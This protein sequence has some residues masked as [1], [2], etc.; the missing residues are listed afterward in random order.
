MGITSFA[1][2][3][4]FAVILVLYYV[5][6]KKWQWGF[7][8]LCS[9]GYYLLSGNPLLIFYPIASVI[10]CYVGARAIGATEKV[11]Y[12]RLALILVLA[13]N[14]GILIVLKYLNFGV[15]TVNG[16]AGL[17][18]QASVWNSIS[19]IISMGG[20][21]YTLT[22]V[23]YVIDIY[24]G[25]SVPEKNF[26]KIALYGL[27]FPTMISGPILRYRSCEQ[28]FFTPH[29]FSYTQVT[30]GLQRMVWGFLK[31]LVIAERL[32]TIVDTVYGNYTAYPGCFIWL[33]AVCFVF[34]LYT[35]FSGCMDIVLGISECFGIT[36]PE[37]FRTPFFSKT[38]TE[39]WRRWHMT[40]G[41]WLKD[42]LFYPLLRTRLFT[43]LNRSM[44]KKLGKKRG[45]QIATFAAMFVLWFMVGI[46]HGGAWHFVIGAGLLHWF[47]IVM[48][49]LLA[50]PFARLCKKISVN[51]SGR[52]VNV[53]RIIRTF[54][55][56]CISDVFFR[57]SS[58]REAFRIFRAGFSSFQAAAFVNGSLLTLGLE[59]KDYAVL[60]V[61]LALL[62]VVSLLQR[63]GSVRDRIAKF[64]LPVRWVIWYALLFYVILLGCYGPGYAA[65]E[66]IYQGF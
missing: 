60:I 62:F 39:Y 36:L 58:L 23:G 64:K 19:F 14:L 66:F 35:D 26:G 52:P 20:S 16:I 43:N 18:G 50:P 2:L 15:Y 13:V 41:A 59:W 21:F 22:L 7:L 53:F 38:V 12:R 24:Y 1:F 34:Q 9:L 45:G 30:R 42:Y 8:L 25:L 4:F 33:A 47:Y 54:V 44:K 56:V 49:E 46:W 48:E 29:T 63:K 37:N 27:Y 57:A 5:I 28:E 17:F 32:G 3:C 11:A 55:L 40:L 51:P 31:K 6:P 61:S 10:A 65:A